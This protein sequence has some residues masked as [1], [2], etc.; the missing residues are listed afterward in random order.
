MFLFQI[1]TQL[2][3][4][5]NINLLFIVYQLKKIFKNLNLYDRLLLYLILLEIP[6]Q[7]TTTYKN[8]FFLQKISQKILKLFLPPFYN[9]ISFYFYFNFSPLIYFRSSG[10]K[11]NNKTTIYHCYFFLKYSEMIPTA[12]TQKTLFH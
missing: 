7:V 11:K 1:E 9:I 8:Y 5:S 4:F 3:N 6:P 2:K 12:L 10:I